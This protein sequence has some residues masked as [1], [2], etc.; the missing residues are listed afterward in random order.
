[1]GAFYK[2]VVFKNYEFA[3]ELNKFRLGL[4]TKR[5]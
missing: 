1:M 4:N 2:Y 5:I 3:E